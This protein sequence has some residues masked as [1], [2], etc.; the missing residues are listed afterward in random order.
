MRL[1]PDEFLVPGIVLRLL[2]NVVEPEATTNAIMHIG[3]L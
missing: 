1:Q 3:G 2:S